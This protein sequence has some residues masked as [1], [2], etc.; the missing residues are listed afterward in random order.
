MEMNPTTQNN[1]PTGCKMCNQ[2]ISPDDFIWRNLASWIG[3]HYTITFL[4][5][6]F[7]V[8][9]VYHTSKLTYLQVEL[10]SDF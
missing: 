9:Q 6:R 2:R 1:S 5:V 4:Y 8:R 7:N 3:Y 10:K